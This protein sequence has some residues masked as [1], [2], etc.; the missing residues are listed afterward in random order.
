MNTMP[1]K[2]F[3]LAKNTL[4]QRVIGPK[5]Y[6]TAQLDGSGLKL[7]DYAGLAYLNM[8]YTPI[9]IVRAKDGFL[10]RFYD[11]YTNKTIEKNSHPE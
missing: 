7:G 5:S 9:G 6:A 3:L 2:D 4:T 11:Q 8:P 10:L 1:A